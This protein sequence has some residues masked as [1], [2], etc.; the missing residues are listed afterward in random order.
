MTGQTFNS[1]VLCLQLH[2]SFLTDDLMLS[3]VLIMATIIL[4]GRILFEPKLLW[5]EGMQFVGLLGFQGGT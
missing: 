4:P 2:I 3:F 1:A 5:G